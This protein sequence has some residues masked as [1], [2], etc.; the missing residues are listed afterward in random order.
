MKT[1]NASKVLAARVAFDQHLDTKHKGCS[2]RVRLRAMG[3]ERVN[4][5]T[6]ARIVEAQHGNGSTVRFMVNQ[7]GQLVNEQEMCKVS[8]EHFGRA[9]MQDRP[10]RLPR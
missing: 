1:V 8:Y 6:W 2:V 9:G 4:V 10:Y 7:H 3:L 5:A